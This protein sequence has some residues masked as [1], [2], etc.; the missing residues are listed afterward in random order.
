MDLKDVADYVLNTQRDCEFTASFTPLDALDV[1][2]Y[3][4]VSRAWRIGRW[5]IWPEAFEF[6]AEGWFVPQTG[7]DDT[8]L[9]IDLRIVG[10]VRIVRAPWW[11][12]VL[13][14]VRHPW[15]QQQKQQKET[16]P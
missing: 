2:T 11:M 12:R 14:R 5:T 16:P 9:S 8:T 1:R 15:D 6:E 3:R 4:F 7:E 10:L 13:W